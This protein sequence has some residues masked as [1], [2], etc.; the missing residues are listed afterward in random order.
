MDN[1]LDK[2][3]II[4]L[5]ILKEMKKP[6][7]SQI[8]CRQLSSMGISMSE[9]TVRFY[10]K[11]IDEMG[12]SQYISKQG[13][14]I[15]QKG[16]DELEHARVYDRVG[17]LASRIDQM[18]FR[19]NFDPDTKKG[20]LIMNISL[21]RKKNLSKA[22]PLIQRV[23][24]HGYA[25][26]RLLALFDSGENCGVHKIPEGWL[27]IATVCSIS[28][29]GILLKKAVPMKSRFGGLLEMENHQ[30]LRFAAI[31][32]YEG[33]TIDPLEIFIRSGM[34]DY[35]GAT[36]TGNGIIGVGFR[37]I[38]GESTE[39]VR[40]IAENLETIGLRGF[41][42]IGMPSQRLYGIPVD[43]RQAGVIVIGGLNPI[44]ILAESGFEV[45]SHAL[46][47]LIDFDRLIEYNQLED[48]A[49]RLKP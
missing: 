30:A 2:K 39:K 33:T 40:Q 44:A 38:P 9:R 22:I 15:T 37:E 5:D 12:L 28:L 4:I 17:F 8:I 42:Q 19:M 26:G 35:L 45:E 25:M 29:N 48:Y 32:C 7:S 27:G 23:F 47:A 20:S 21:L 13:R 24:E 1:Q 49:S 6:V 18:T 43:D 16:L 46:S 36:A 34:T 31:I 10:L 14:L 41:F 3:Q 11:E